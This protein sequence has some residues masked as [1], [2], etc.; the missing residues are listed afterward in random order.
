LPEQQPAHQLAI[1]LHWLSC[2]S[3]KR[4]VSRDTGWDIERGEP[5]VLYIRE[6]V[7]P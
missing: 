1:A 2:T 7:S 6:A 5:D 3:A 4:H